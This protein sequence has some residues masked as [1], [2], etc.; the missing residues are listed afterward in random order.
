M[1]EAMSTIRKG[2]MPG[3]S[4]V[5]VDLV[6]HPKWRKQM[7]EH[8]SKL[9]MACYKKGE[10]TPRMRTAV[11]SILY[12]GKGDRDLCASHRPVSLTDAAMRIIDKAL[13]RAIN[14]VLPSI[15]C[16]INRAF[17]P[18]EHVENDTLSMAEAARYSLPDQT[19]GGAR[20]RMS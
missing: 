3:E 20:Y 6:A 7:S 10:L 8:L 15:L 1:R 19:G 18:G 9:A 13:Q 12:K 11:I 5:T 2:T 16:G 4:G 14:G 17:L